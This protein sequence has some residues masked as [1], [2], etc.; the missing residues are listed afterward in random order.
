M[1]FFGL[2]F[3]LVLVSNLTIANKKIELAEARQLFLTCHENTEQIKKLYA[4]LQVSQWEN[5]ALHQAYLGAAEAMMAETTLNVYKKLSYFS[6]GTKKL[7]EA[8]KV[9]PHEV[10]IRFL[11]FTVQNAAPTM[12]MYNKNLVE[13]KQKLL[14]FLNNTP[15]NDV[16]LKQAILA[17]KSY[18]NCLQ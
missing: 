15:T 17:Y 14:S 10:E 16:P 6:D 8:C 11:R 2:T 1:R 18:C 5:K 4:S 7:E 9:A 13:D 3:L 12:L